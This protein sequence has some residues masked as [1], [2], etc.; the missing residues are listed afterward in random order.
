[1]VLEQIPPDV[2][3]VLDLGTGDGRLLAMIRSARPAAAGVG[4]DGSEPMLEAARARF[5][6]EQEVKVVGHDMAHPLPDLGTFDAVV[7][8][9]AIHHLEDDRK[10][11]L[12]AEVFE[13]L[14]PGGVF[15]NLEHVSSPTP[16]LHARWRCCLGIDGEEEDPSNRCLDVQTQLS[17]LRESGFRDV[18]CYWKWME[19]AL[20]CGLK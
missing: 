9:F 7:S 18:D 10:Q 11:E 3:R 19:M 4:L 20:L 16:E 5:A 6:G 2:R 15:C 17:W 13:I 14:E 8:S 1:V 12:Y